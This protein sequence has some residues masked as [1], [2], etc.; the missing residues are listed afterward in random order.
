MQPACGPQVSPSAAGLPKAG[1]LLPGHT[2]VWDCQRAAPVP[3]VTSTSPAHR[4]RH[5]RLSTGLRPA[6]H[7][8]C[9]WREQRLFVRL[10][11]AIVM[12]WSL[13]KSRAFLLCFLSGD[14][15]SMGVQVVNEGG[16]VGMDGIQVDEECGCVSPI[17]LR[18]SGR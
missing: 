17:V 9:P 6:C 16:W 10:G 4:R 12:I 3:V 15:C 13:N 7:I 1:F 11:G 5:S 2:V 18:P 8:C 14:E